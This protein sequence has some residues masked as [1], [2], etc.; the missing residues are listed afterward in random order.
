MI[1]PAPSVRTATAAHA[2]SRRFDAENEPAFPSGHTG[3]GGNGSVGTPAAP[4][5]YWGDG[6]AALV[7]FALVFPLLMLLM[8]GMVSAGVAWNQQLQITHAAREGARYG[9]TVRRD[10]AFVAPTD[11]WAEAVSDVT[12]GRAG[13]ELEVDGATICVALVQGSGGTLRVVGTP[14]LPGTASADYVRAGSR[15]GGV[16]S[17][18]NNGVQPCIANE[19]YPVTVDDDGRRVQLTMTRP[20]KIEAL[21]LS[22]PF[23]EKAD[24]TAKAEST[25]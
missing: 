20:G 3:D 18:T 25:A 13:G 23:T 5:T 17:Y 12:L 6:G 4:T 9:A 15:S 22:I 21:A 14:A 19:T 1:V 16:W 24:A 2:S 10:Q 11:N 7:E 8:L